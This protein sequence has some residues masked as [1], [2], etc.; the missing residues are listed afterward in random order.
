MKLA[1][2]AAL[3]LLAMVCPVLARTFPVPPD[4]PAITVTVPDGWKISKIDYGY[5][6][7]S[8][9]EDVFFSV[10]HADNAKDLD[11]MMNLNTSWM[12]ENRIKPVKPTKEEGSVNGVKLTHYEFD[13]TDENGKTLVDFMLVQAGD[14][15]AMMTLW[16]SVEERNKHEA[17]IM[18]IM[19]SVRPAQ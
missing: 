1:L 12:K 19:N 6:A 17:E 13:T 4:H 2:R 10:E 15:L 9:E 8:P 14:S 18:S 16:G 3:L 7:L 11:A 5:S